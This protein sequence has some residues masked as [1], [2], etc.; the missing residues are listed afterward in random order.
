[1]GPRSRILLVTF[2]ALSLDGI[3]GGFPLEIPKEAISAPSAPG[4]PDYPLPDNS[5]PSYSPDGREVVF[6]TDWRGVVFYEGRPIAATPSIW[7][8]STVDGRLRSIARATPSLSSGRHPAWSPTGEWIATASSYGVGSIIW[9]V[10]PDGSGAT[11][12]TAQRPQD[13]KLESYAEHDQPAWSPDGKQIA[14]VSGPTNA[15][16]IWIVNADGTGLRRVIRLP[17]IV[18]RPRIVDHPSF[19][20]DGRQ[21]VFSAS[22]ENVIGVEHF[23]GFA[24]NLFIVNVDGT[25]LKQ[26]TTGAF[27]D[28]GPSWSERG[29]LFASNRPGSFGI[30]LIQPDGVGLQAIPSA[31]GVE[32]TWSPDRSKI[33]FSRAGN[34]VSNYVPGPGPGIYE[35]EFS[36]GSVRPLVQLRGRFIV[37][38]IMP[39]VPSKVISLKQT[40]LIHTAILFAPDLGFNPVNLVDRASI[41]FG[42][43]GDEH[44]LT[45]CAEDGKSLVCDF[46]TALTGFQPGDTQGILRLVGGKTPLRFNCEGR[47]AVQIVP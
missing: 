21:I 9:L 39:G 42:R 47:G 25:G 45:S 15:R 46:K 24:F 33:A 44:S 20:P 18:D 26:L 37:I 43:T 3:F 27:L 17:Q 5:H 7:A 35:Y 23:L 2:A 14:F 30:R 29:I 36:T 12:L 38:D 22:T 41:T 31:V 10:R 34:Y 11:P 8:V 4:A 16:E 32:P 1:M 6:Q 28:T 40:E 19:S 13:A